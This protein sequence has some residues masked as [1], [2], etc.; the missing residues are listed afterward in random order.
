VVLKRITKP[1]LIG[2]A[3]FIYAVYIV[4]K[5]LNIGCHCASKSDTIVNSLCEL[6]AA[7]IQW[8]IDHKS[9][10]VTNVTWKDLSPYVQSDFWNHPIA[11]ENLPH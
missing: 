11:G 7:K 5:I 6:D 9:A 2:I 3:V 8:A 4:A 1:V 10:A